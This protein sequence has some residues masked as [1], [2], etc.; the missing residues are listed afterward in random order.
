MSTIN[1][2]ELSFTFDKGEF[3]CNELASLPQTFNNI[4]NGEAQL[5]KEIDRHIDLVAATFEI[6][7]SS[8]EE[9]DSMTKHDRLTKGKEVFMEILPRIRD[10]AKDK[11]PF[12]QLLFWLSFNWWYFDV[13]ITRRLS[14][15]SD[16]R[17]FKNASRLVNELIVPQLHQQIQSEVAGMEVCNMVIN[18]G[19]FA[20]M[21]ENEKSRLRR[22]ITD[23]Q[24]FELSQ[25]SGYTYL[26]ITPEGKPI[27][28][29]CT[30][31]GGERAFFDGTRL[32]THDQFQTC[33]PKTVLFPGGYKVNS[34]RCTIINGRIYPLI[35]VG[36][37]VSHT[38]GAWMGMVDWSLDQFI[39]GWELS[40]QSA[41]KMQL[42]EN[43]NVFV[44]GKTIKPL[45]EFQPSEIELLDSGFALYHP[46]EFLEFSNIQYEKVMVVDD[47]EDWIDTISSTLGKTQDGGPET[48]VRM[49][50]TD[51]V[52][53][54]AKILET[55]PD[56]LVLDVHLTHDEQ[57]DGL[58]IANQ[59]FKSDF[60][61]FVLLAS[62]YPDE[63]LAAMKI[64]VAGN[65]R[66]VE[67]PGKNPERI[68]KLLSQRS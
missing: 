22:I 27:A 31:L 21:F 29:Y 57:F 12:E 19:H 30:S 67:A 52:A 34:T 42:K 23:I 10:L 25:A 11:S 50:T 13:E 68:R 59:L 40:E 56:A 4:F 14:E 58:W 49:Q 20:I 44:D 66:R 63:Q 37:R 55:N 1:K 7:C 41:G 2:G 17:H 65:G 43:G 28:R 33:A 46:S 15:I 54:L 26:D 60:Q 5:Q 47:R 39:K 64:L 35:D 18:F 16:Y 36:D 32:M 8:K 6:R 48:M 62:S 53:A 45:G 51:K 24:L 38:T 3:F 61:G 9:Y